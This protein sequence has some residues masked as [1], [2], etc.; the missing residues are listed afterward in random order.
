MA[1]KTGDSWSWENRAF[2]SEWSHLEM[3]APVVFGKD[4]TTSS[5]G[6][7]LSE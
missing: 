3:S 1:S 4:T 2:G 6:A 5:L 7:L